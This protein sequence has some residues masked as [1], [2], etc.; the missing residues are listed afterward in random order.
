M[1]DETSFYMK[2]RQMLKT[3][4]R[5]KADSLALGHLNSCA[6]YKYECGIIYGLQLALDLMDETLKQHT[7][8]IE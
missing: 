3:A 7:K 4:A 6:D 5:E 2:T 1:T 8:E